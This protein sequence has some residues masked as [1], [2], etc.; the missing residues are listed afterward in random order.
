MGGR[1]RERERIREIRAMKKIGKRLEFEPKHGPVV[2][3]SIHSTNLSTLPLLFE[4][5]LG[6][7][8]DFSNIDH[9]KAVPFI[10][11]A[12]YFPMEFREQARVLLKKFGIFLEKKWKKAEFSRK[13]NLFFWESN[14]KI[15]DFLAKKPF[16]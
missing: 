16:F 3:L 1:K 14:G 8:L 9:C 2:H 7:C 15:R 10:D 4:L 6:F 11:P 12:E 5:F 13:K